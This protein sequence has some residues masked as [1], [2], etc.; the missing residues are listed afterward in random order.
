MLVVR[1][2][3][4]F[5][6]LNLAMDRRAPA[7]N[8]EQTAPEISPLSHVRVLSAYIVARARR[9]LASLPTKIAAI[10]DT[11]TTLDLA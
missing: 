7:S 1:R 8:P 11:E 4:V 6:T 10:S 3:K 2:D 5:D 9:D